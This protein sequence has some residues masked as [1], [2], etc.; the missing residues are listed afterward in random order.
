MKQPI[1]TGL[2]TALVTPFR[3]G[4]VD[5]GLLEELIR[6]QIA[7]GADAIVLCGTTG[8]SP[9]LTKEEKRDIFR[10][11]VRAA[12]GRCKII[13]GTGSNSTATAVELSCMARQ[14]GAD[15]LLVV[16]P[17]YNKTTQSGLLRH[18]AAVCDA[19]KLPVIAYTVPSR[20]GMDI[21]VEACRALAEMEYM[22]GLKDAAGNISKTAHIL[23]G[24]DLPVYSGND[25]QTAAIMALG[26]KGVISVASNVSPG[27]MKRLTDAALAGDFE[28]AAALQHRLLPLMDALFAQV[29]PIPVKEAMELL[30]WRVGKCRMPLDGCTEENQA[31]LRKCIDELALPPYNGGDFK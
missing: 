14:E 17:Y 26:G 24:C 2:C 8:E 11:G 29:N 6:W 16:T 3:E 1:F 18:Y 25:D 30:G 31:K 12:A 20:T 5:L 23:A 21:S 10:T 28:T 19:A 27:M 13:A 15:G 7:S 4:K 22:A 9:T